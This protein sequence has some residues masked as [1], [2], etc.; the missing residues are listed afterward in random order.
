MVSNE[1]I[2]KKMKLSD[3]RYLGN[4]EDNIMNTIFNL[5]L[6]IVSKWGKKGSHRSRR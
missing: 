5:P 1:W 3:I 6:L 4:G 2:R